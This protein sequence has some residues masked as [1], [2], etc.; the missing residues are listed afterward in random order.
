MIGSPA[1]VRC[2]FH[3]CQGVPPAIS[4]SSWKMADDHFLSMLIVLV[5]PFSIT[6]PRSVKVTV[7][8]PLLEY[9]SRNSTCISGGH[10]SSGD[11]GILFTCMSM[12]GFTKR[13]LRRSSLTKC[14]QCM[15]RRCA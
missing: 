15:D 2:F 12:F 6:G 1:A 8:A 9:Y 3:R 11:F 10:F 5:E 14:L 13:I 7:V 4:I